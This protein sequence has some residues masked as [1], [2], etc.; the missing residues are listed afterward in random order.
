MTKTLTIILLSG[1]FF[2]QGC[3]SASGQVDNIKAALLDNGIT[4]EADDTDIPVADVGNNG[5][6]EEFN[7]SI[8]PVGL[9]FTYSLVY[10]LSPIDEVDMDMAKDVLNN[11]DGLSISTSTLKDKMEMPRKVVLKK[12][13]RQ[14]AEDG[15]QP[16]VIN[17]DKT[18]LNL[19]YLSDDFDDD[20]GEMLIVNFDGNE[21]NI[22]TI[23]ANF[24]KIIEVASRY[25]GLDLGNK[26]SFK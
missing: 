18:E 17:R 26:I 15:Y 3:F 4:E 21:L 24:E 23:S 13:K 8:G 11:I 10:F 6:D 22:V 14:L 2:L 1:L 20:G 5:D 25:K 12:L 16:I 7:F 19:I 9:F